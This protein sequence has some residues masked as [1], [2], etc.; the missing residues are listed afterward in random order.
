MNKEP[1]VLPENKFEN[2]PL[3]M[4]H[5]LIA[6]FHEFIGN[7]DK[8]RKDKVNS[9]SRRLGV[10]AVEDAFIEL[11]DNGWLKIV[12][13]EA[14]DGVRIYFYDFEKGRYF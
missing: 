13:D 9:L 14:K 4:K 2:M 10:E 1:I 3:D 5:V 12:V 6:I 11:Y 8:E 7:L